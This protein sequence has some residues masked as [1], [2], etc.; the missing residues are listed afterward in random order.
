[1]AG[2]D[3]GETALMLGAIATA[4]ADEQW[5]D[6]VQAGRDAVKQY[7]SGGETRGLPALAE[8]FGEKMA[9]RAAQWLGDKSQKL[10]SKNDDDDEA[11]IAKWNERHA[12]V[13]AG[14]KSAV[15]QEFKT[16]EGYT[17]FKLLSSTAF[18]EWNAEHQVLRVIGKNVVMVPETKLW[19]RHPK[20]RKYQDIGFFPRRNVPDYYNLW[21]G[22]AV[23]PR[24][25]D[26]SK[27]LAHVRENGCQNNDAL[28]TW[29][30]AWLADIFQHPEIKCGTSLVFR[31]KQ[32][33]G[34]TK[35]G[36]VMRGLLGVH[37][38]SV[39]ESRYV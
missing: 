9:S 35:L 28:Y 27:F 16:S 7:G 13:L 21:R 39:A 15:L 8:T 37:Y 26:C 12:H 25:G 19:M 10:E 30:M 32:G 14:G 18:H 34:K 38:K 31:G 2:L 17:D 6:R 4:A 24:K 1:R 36:E 23:E 22:F 29:V 3:E 11:I 33:V 5:E 20:R